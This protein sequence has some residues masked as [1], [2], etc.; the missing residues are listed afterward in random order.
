MKKEAQL[1]A[2]RAK[3]GPLSANKPRKSIFDVEPNTS[4][5]V[6]EQPKAKTQAPTSV[7]VAKDV[8]AKVAPKQ[9]ATKSGAVSAAKETTRAKLHDVN[10]PMPPDLLDMI[11]DGAKAIN[12]NGLSKAGRITAS[13]IMRSLLSIYK[14]IDVDFGA[15]DSEESLNV[16][17]KSAIQARMRG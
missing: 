15:V 16:A 12:R 10:V 11:Q 5:E 9:A 3:L 2:M 14:E 13:S 4:V 8:T 17:V 7:A 6:K 1:E